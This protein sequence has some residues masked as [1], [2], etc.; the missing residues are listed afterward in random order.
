[1]SIPVSIPGLP[2]LLIPRPATI[3][4]L[5][6]ADAFPLLPQRFQSPWGIWQ[7][8]APVVLADSVVALNFKQTW[9]TTTAPLEQ[10]AFADYNK[11]QTP[12]GARLRMTRGGNS[13][14]RQQFLASIEQFAAS[15]ELVD[16]VTPERTYTSANIIEYEYN[17]AADSGLGLMIVDIRLEQIRTS[18]AAT[19]GAPTNFQNTAQPFAATVIGL[20]QIQPQAPVALPPLS[21]LVVP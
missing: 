18:V 3:L 1:M 14:S 11:V 13:T 17:R 16:I 12:F 8:G 9:N 7:N 20:G 6:V 21:S 19:T 5:L 15:L 4:T 2:P 10:G